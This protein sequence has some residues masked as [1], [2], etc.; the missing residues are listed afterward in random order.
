[1]RAA[2]VSLVAVTTL[3]VAAPAATAE[4]WRG[5]DAHHD[6]TS[7]THGAQPPPCG[8]DSVATDPDDELR[9]ITGLRVTHD[10]DAITVRVSMRE[11]RRRD[12]STTWTIH[13]RV[14]S[15][16]FVINVL[17][18]GPPGKILTFMTKEPE[19]PPPDECG[20]TGAI[21]TSRSCAGL[22][23]T[24]DP[25]DDTLVVTMSRE[26]L[27][28]PRWVQVG[29]EVFGGF[30]GTTE[31]F[32]THSDEWA[33]PGDDTSGLVPPYGPRVHRG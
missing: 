4:T 8:T 13:L 29:V 28:E 26:C 9:D 10:P 17:R 14:P 30:S 18:P 25:P 15:G 12:H 6:V 2:L 3:G 16:A 31:E 5:A 33:E 32:T 21:T 1:V 7:Y 11:L 24:V 27:K 20:A 19:F 22:R 23:G